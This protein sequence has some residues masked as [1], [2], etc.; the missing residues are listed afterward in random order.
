MVYGLLSLVAPEAEAE[1][2]KPDYGKTV[3]EVFAD[4][5]LVMI[6]LYSR[7]MP[8]AYVSHPEE[9]DGEYG[10]RSW[11]PHWDDSG[12]AEAFGIPEEDCPWKASAGHS[13]EIPNPENIK[14]YQICLS[15]VFYDT[16]AMVDE[17]MGTY[18]L[19]NPKKYAD[20]GVHPFLR[21][22]DNN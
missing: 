6:Q 1:A 10:R 7:L 3:E 9:Y 21:A 8:L 11:V 2:L 19:E 15:G 17:V 18:S 13:T 22:C 14:P 4:T 16:V 20:D 12:F 5:V